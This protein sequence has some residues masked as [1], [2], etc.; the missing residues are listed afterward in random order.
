[1]NA[2]SH[3]NTQKQLTKQQISTHTH[4]RLA[5]GE[6]RDL[7][8]LAA[9]HQLALLSTRKRARGFN[10]KIRNVKWIVQKDIRQKLHFFELGRFDF[11]L[12]I[13]DVWRKIW[14]NDTVEKQN[15]RGQQGRWWD[16]CADSLWLLLHLRN[17]WRR[18]LHSP[19]R[20]WWSYCLVFEC[21]GCRVQG[22]W[23]IE[24]LQNLVA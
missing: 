11:F 23:A 13:S 20:Q 15:L 19:L 1:M 4:L 22:S 14:I 5:D 2:H 24:C 3:D 6:M 21:A 18:A 9:A 16:P 10:T 17:R 7:T 12:Q 8:I